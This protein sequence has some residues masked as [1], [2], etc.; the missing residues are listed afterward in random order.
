MATAAKT[1]LLKSGF[2]N[3]FWDPKIKTFFPKQQFFSQTQGY[4]NRWPIETL[5]KAG[6]KLFSWFKLRHKNKN[7]FLFISIY[8]A[9]FRS[10]KWLGKFQVFF[11]NSRLR[12]NPENEFAFF[13]TLVHLFL[14]M[15]MS[16]VGKFPWSWF[17]GDGTQKEKIVVANLFPP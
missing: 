9:F 6:T 13:Q 15:R 5:K 10:G 17:L 2:V 14:S 12:G 8:Q 11:K 4:Q 16:N 7:K 3:W 1:S